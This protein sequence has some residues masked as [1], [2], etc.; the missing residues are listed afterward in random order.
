MLTLS[1]VQYGKCMHRGR[2][3][4]TS[5]KDVSKVIIQKS[6]EPISNLKLQKLLYYVQ[7]WSLAMHDR[8]AFH[9]ETQ[10]WVHGPVVPAAFYEY[11]HFRWNPI[12]IP[13][14][15]VFISEAES[16][17]IENMLATY[18]SFTAYQLESLTH[19]ESPW[20]EARIGLD[21]KTSSRAV[22]TVEAMKTFFT[23]KLNG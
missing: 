15:T 4:M 5:V 18:G 23:K 17:H 7:G 9:E 12:E 10:A 13:S 6:L 14:E 3:I 16:S 21:P 1:R 8:I 11:K 19:E 20:I 22:I 2:K